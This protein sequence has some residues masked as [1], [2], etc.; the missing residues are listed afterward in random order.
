MFNFDCVEVSSKVSMNVGGEV[1]SV[2]VKRVEGSRVVIVWRGY[3]C[4]K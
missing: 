4:G 1:S 3:N 2:R